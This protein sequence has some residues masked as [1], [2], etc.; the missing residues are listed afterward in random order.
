M[1][2]S[3]ALPEG[4]VQTIRQRSIGVAARSPQRWERSLGRR[5][6]FTLETTGRVTVSCLDGMLWLTLDGDGADYVLAPGQ[7]LRVPADQRAV[8]QAL[9][10]SRFGV[11]P[12]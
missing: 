1:S 11:T 2:A 4:I 9:A 5:E 3:I 12:A 7:A 8:I 6:L 10:E